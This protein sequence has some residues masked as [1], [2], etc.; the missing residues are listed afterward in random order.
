MFI[1]CIFLFLAKLKSVNCTVALHLSG[2]KI[3]KLYS[4]GPF[5]QGCFQEDV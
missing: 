2:P 1:F 5:F 3:S 4:N